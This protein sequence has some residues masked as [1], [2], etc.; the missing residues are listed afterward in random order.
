MKDA[1]R[2]R[3][4]P[5][6]DSEHVVD[7]GESVA[8]AQLAHRPVLQPDALDLHVGDTADSVLVGR[9]GSLGSGVAL[10]PGGEV[11]AE[12]VG[13]IREAVGLV[14]RPLRFAFP[15]E[16]PLASVPGRLGDAVLTV[17]TGV[18]RDP[19][20]GSGRIAALDRRLAPHAA[21]S[22]WRAR[23]SSTSAGSIRRAAPS[24]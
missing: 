18:A 3:G 15:F 16:G 17:A 11:V 12:C 7:Q 4:R 22:L 20:H 19:D 21:S 23:K 24:L 8:A 5:S 1:Y 13:S 14:N 6:F 2:S 9:V 10:G